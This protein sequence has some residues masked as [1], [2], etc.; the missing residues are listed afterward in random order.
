MPE[1]TRGRSTADIVATALLFLGQLAASALLFVPAMLGTTLATCGANCDSA[2]V[3]RVVHSTWTG[4]L[5]MVSGVGIALLVAACGTLVSG[6]RG[7]LMWKWPALGLA[8]VMGCFLITMGLWVN[9]T[10]GTG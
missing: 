8:I 6:L 2:E 4:A 5:I 7:T 3:S 1:P 9:P 10:P